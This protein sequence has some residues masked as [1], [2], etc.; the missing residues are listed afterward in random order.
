VKRGEVG[1]R[2]WGGEA[3]TAALLPLWQPHDP[4]GPPVSMMY[5]GGQRGAGCVCRLDATNVRS[6]QRARVLSYRGSQA[7]GPRAGD[8]AS[9][10]LHAER[11]LDAALDAEELAGERR[12]SDARGG[13]RMRG[14]EGSCAEA[15]GEDLAVVRRLALSIDEARERRAQHA[16]NGRP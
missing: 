14:R 1:R 10:T 3:K 12:A 7:L 5:L 15:A 2:G 6:G 13:H 9:R 11:R 16:G 4:T 8:C